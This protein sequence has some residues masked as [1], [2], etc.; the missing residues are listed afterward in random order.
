L[1]NPDKHIKPVSITGFGELHREGKGV[2]GTGRAW[3]YFQILYGDSTD[4]YH[5]SEL[6]KMQE[7]K[8]Q[9][10]EVAAYN[11]LKDAQNDKEA[12]ELLYNQYKTWYPSPITYTAEFDGKEYTKDA[13][14]IMQL[15]ADCAFMLRWKGDRLDCRGVLTKLGVI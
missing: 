6:W 2:K 11:I 3:L 12:W 13:V 1:F 9:F 8:R 5:G 15:Y 14:D 7:P 4:C 10:G